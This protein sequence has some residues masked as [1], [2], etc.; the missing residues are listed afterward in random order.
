[1]FPIAKEFQ[2]IFIVVTLIIIGAQ[3]ISVPYAGLLWVPWLMLAFFIR[4]FHRNIP[5]IPL[6]NIS[7]VDGVVAEISDEFDP[8]L[9]RAS[10]RYTIIQN[11]WGEFN[12]H[13]PTEGK[14][15]Q[16]WVKEPVNNR[17]GLVFWVRTDE[18]DDVV[19]HVELNSP[20]QH[21]STTLHPGERVGQGRRCGFVA[22]KC[23]VHIYFPDNVQR[24]A[25]VG[26]KITAGKHIITNFVH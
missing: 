10:C 16:L 3:T 2:S 18:G 15:E 13:S 20:F 4:D 21:A 5:P 14:I 19:V 17:K 6:A 26:D 23:K 1:M 22:M 8:F 11:R 9:E 12:L 25:Q 7:P 24:H